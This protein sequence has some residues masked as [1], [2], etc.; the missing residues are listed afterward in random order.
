MTQVK[1]VYGDITKTMD[2]LIYNPHTFG[3]LAFIHTIFV[4]VR[5]KVGSVGSKAVKSFLNTINCLGFMLLVC[6][7]LK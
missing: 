4:E 6:L 7:I 1:K 2:N 3:N 5:I